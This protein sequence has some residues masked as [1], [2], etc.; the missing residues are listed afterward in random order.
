MT[1]ETARTIRQLQEKAQE[2]G[3]KDILEQLNK[4][5]ENWQ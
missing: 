4:L 5:H 2:E 1:L 3:R